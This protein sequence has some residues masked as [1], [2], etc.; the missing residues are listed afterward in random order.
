MGGEHRISGR[1]DGPRTPENVIGLTSGV[2]SISVGSSHIC[3]VTAEGGV[4]C[5]GAYKSSLGFGTDTDPATPGDVVGLNSD[6]VSIS[7]GGGHTCVLT[8][9]GGVK[10]W[11]GNFSG[12]LGDGTTTG[13]VSPVDVVGFGGG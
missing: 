7:V 6:V 3:V 12:Q 8:T 5:W 2:V 11:G 4:K 10:C 9:E 13:R 1:R